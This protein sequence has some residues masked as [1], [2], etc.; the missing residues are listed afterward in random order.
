MWVVTRECEFSIVV[1][2]GCDCR[3]RSKC[4]RVKNGLLFANDRK[5]A[6]SRRRPHYPPG[7]QRDGPAVPAQGGSFEWR[8]NRYRQSGPIGSAQDTVIGVE[9]TPASGKGEIA[10]EHGADTRNAD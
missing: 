7:V 5:G 1:D 9:P 10:K 8:R 3:L 6:G 4:H 2:R